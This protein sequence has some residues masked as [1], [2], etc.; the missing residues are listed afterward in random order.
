MSPITDAQVEAVRAAVQAVPRGAVT[1]YGDIARYVGLSS[2]RI[3]GW[4]MRTDSVDL[5]WHRVL[6]ADGRPAP[7]LREQQLATLRGEGAR[8][9]D[10]RVDLGTCRHRFPDPT[11]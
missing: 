1:T 11:R 6:R 5:P 3:V 10:G 9:T 8:V 2:P 7:H 4:I